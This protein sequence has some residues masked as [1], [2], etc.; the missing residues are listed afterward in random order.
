V[1]GHVGI[2]N[3]KQLAWF[4]DIKISNKHDEQ[5]FPIGK[6]RGNTV[7]VPRA[8]SIRGSRGTIP[9]VD[10]NKAGD[11]ALAD[12]ATG[13]AQ[14]LYVWGVVRYHDGF[15][16]GRETKFC[17]RYNWQ[18]RSAENKISAKYGRYHEY[19]NDAA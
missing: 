9:T 2:K 8:I 7:L 5:A 18:I 10:L 15:T 6:P 3:A 16:P 19:G 17:H 11:A 13:K 12:N 4:V 14:Y 1:L